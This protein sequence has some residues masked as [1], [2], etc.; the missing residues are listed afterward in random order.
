MNPIALLFNPQTPS[1]YFYL[2]CISLLT[3]TVKILE[4]PGFLLSEEFFHEFYH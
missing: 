4:Y 1:P 2:L 3:H